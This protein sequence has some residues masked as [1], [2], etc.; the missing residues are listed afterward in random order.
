MGAVPASL[1][2][3]QEMHNG[4]GDVSDP[5]AEALR[6]ACD[7][8]TH[9]K[10]TGVSNTVIKKNLERLVAAKA[11]LEVRCLVV[12]GCT[13]DMPARYAYLES[14][15]ISRKDVVELEYFDYARS[16]YQA[17]GIPDTMPKK[18]GAQ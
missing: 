10:Y 17:L 3:L 1:P 9:Q 12:H 8:A 5:C 14:I 7:D 4:R 15:G 13:E 6:E 2:A 11:K 16:K 18:G